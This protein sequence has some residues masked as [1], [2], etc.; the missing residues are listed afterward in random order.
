VRTLA[1]VAR[2]DPEL[3]QALQ[4]SSTCQQLREEANA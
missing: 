1:D 4:A 3:G 2:L